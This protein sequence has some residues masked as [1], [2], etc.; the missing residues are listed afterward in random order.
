MGGLSAVSLRLR[1]YQPECS[2]P[3]DCTHNEAPSQAL[4]FAAIWLTF[5]HSQKREFVKYI[6]ACVNFCQLVGIFAPCP[7]SPR[8][9]CSHSPALIPRLL[10]SQRITHTCLWESPG[11]SR[12][13]ESRHEQRLTSACR[14]PNG[15]FRL[16]NVETYQNQMTGDTRPSCESLRFQPSE[17]ENQYQQCWFKFG[18]TCFNFF[19]FFTFLYVNL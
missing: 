12:R 2:S 13:R 11:F 10:A 3:I 15:G 7:L 19:F 16:R 1:S 8:P 4:L 17:P 18:N 9:R 5:R 6:C 14:E